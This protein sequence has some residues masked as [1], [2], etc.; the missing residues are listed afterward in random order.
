VN[1]SFQTFVKDARAIAI[2]K[3]LAWD[4]QL[5]ADGHAM[6]GE[7]WNL[8][9]ISRASPPPSDWLNDLGTDARTVDVLNS[10]SS[11]GPQR[12]YRKCALSRAWQDLIKACV[13]DQ[14]FIRRNTTRHTL[15][16]VIRPLRVL[17]TCVDKDEPWALTADDASF[18]FETAKLVQPSGKLA[19]LVFGVIADLLDANHLTDNSPLCPSLSREKKATAKRA[20]FAKTVGQLREDLESRKSANRLPDRR[21]LW[22]LVQIVFTK[23]PKS[24]LDVLRF[25]QIRI[26][27]LTGLRVGEVARLPADWRRTRDYY[28]DKGRPAGEAGGY[29]HSLLLRYFAEKQRNSNEDS[30][31]L[32]ESTQ[33]VP[34]MFEEILAETLDKIVEVTGPLRR[35]LRRQV[36]TGRILPDFPRT[37][38]VSAVELYTVLT[39]NPFLLD[40]VLDQERHYVQRYAVNYDPSI[41]DDLRE[42]QLRELGRGRLNQAVYMYLHRLDGVP[43]RKRDGSILTGAKERDSTFLRVGEVE[44]FLSTQVASKLSD[45]T[46]I[47]LSVGELSAWELMWLAPK[48]ALSDGRNEGLCDIT[49]YC[50][51]GRIDSSMITDALCSSARN[52]FSVYGQTEEDRRL[53]LNPHSLRHLQNTELFRLR[54]ADTIITKHYGRRQLA[55]SHQYD[56]R[57]LAE[58]LAQIELE[59]EVEAQL[60]DRAATVARMIKAGKASGPIVEAFRRIQR[61]SGEDAALDYLSA[62]ADGF[63]S[64]PY[65]HCINS[66]LVE[67]CPKHL[68]CFAGCRHFSA[69]DLP[70]HRNNLVRLESRLRVAVLSIEAR[71]SNSI[72]RKNQLMHAR[73]RLEGVQKILAT[74]PGEPVFPE[75]PDLSRSPSMV[76]RSVLDGDD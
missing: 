40:R 35:T 62:E 54:I 48:R 51:V 31:A 29:S 46:A 15:D 56:H 76:K 50:A 32:F 74:A 16:G 44:D 61:E 63:H 75:G 41:F 45:V 66:F 47:R 5:D 12:E 7:G 72:G 60:G 23:Q 24:F 17:A 57:S 25:A 1:S 58:E 73:T 21:A 14:L 70:E 43:F 2:A 71:K 9:K 11:K 39:G 34:A 55:Q 42:M 33:H 69:S 19:D 49:R 52:L 37:D 53:T 59:P 8:T 30:M 6:K 68:E 27:L 26:L 3:N 65:G 22:E 67:P 38:L 4:I 18:A 36:E 10:V 28:D 13:M 64:T 20:R